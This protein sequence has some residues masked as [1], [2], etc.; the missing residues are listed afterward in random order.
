MAARAATAKLPRSGSDRDVLRGHLAKIA[1]WKVL[2]LYIHGTLGG[3][4]ASRR[5]ER[6]GVDLQPE[7]V[8]QL[9]DLAFEDAKAVGAK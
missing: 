9:A 5:L 3:V 1:V 8:S 7:G 2:F 4:E 6:I